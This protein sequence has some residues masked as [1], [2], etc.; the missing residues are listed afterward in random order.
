MFNHFM[1]LIIFYFHGKF[2]IVL[3]A[4]SRAHVNYSI[5]TIHIDIKF[6]GVFNES[7]NT[8]EAL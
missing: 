7:I 1:K 6:C 3:K 2:Y 5:S 4:N 8:A